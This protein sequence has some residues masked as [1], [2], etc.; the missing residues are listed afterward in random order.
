M[1]QIIATSS[2]LGLAI[3]PRAGVYSATKHSVQA[4]I[5]CLRE[6][7]NGT[8]VKAS[9]IN[10]GSV[11]TPWFKGRNVDTSRMLSPE[12]VARTVRYIVDQPETS[13]IDHV[14]LKPGRS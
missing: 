10:P 9:T 5:G 3:A 2:N 14:L 13:N 6:E 8:N 12:D 11:A 7:L 4:M 1:G